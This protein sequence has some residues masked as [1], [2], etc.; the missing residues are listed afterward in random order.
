MEEQQATVTITG[1]KH[2]YKGC[3][4][5]GTAGKSA[6]STANVNLLGERCCQNNAAACRP[7]AIFVDAL[8]PGK[9]RNGGITERAAHS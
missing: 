5:R 3:K 4:H 7:C 2:K 8:F 6:G 1:S 9:W